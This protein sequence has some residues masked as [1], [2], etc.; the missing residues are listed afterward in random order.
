MAHCVVRRRSAQLSS[1]RHERSQ[2]LGSGSSSMRSCSSPGAC[3]PP[4]RNLSN[5]WTICSDG[6]ENSP[7]HQS[8][9]LWEFRKLGKCSD[10]LLA[11]MVRGIMMM[12]E[13]LRLQ[14]RQSC[15]NVL[16]AYS[17]NGWVEHNM[18]RR[19]LWNGSF[20]SRKAPW[21]ARNHVTSK[22]SAVDLVRY[23]S[24]VKARA[25]LKFTGILFPSLLV[26]VELLSMKRTYYLFAIVF[27]LQVKRVFLQCRGS[28]LTSVTSSRSASP[29]SYY[30]TPLDLFDHWV[31][32]WCYMVRQHSFKIVKYIN[33]CR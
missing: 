21:A 24:Q 25:P 22:M 23:L 9:F 20:H 4:F 18:S 5:L 10:E 32:W 27:S 11:E 28:F 30:I 15:K 33:D 19:E 29:I 8:Y 14:S 1:A 31:N 2:W 3:Q 7:C 26:I 12:T 13:L 17:S 6:A 16:Q